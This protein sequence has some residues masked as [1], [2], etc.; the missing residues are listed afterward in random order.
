MISFVYLIMMNMLFFRYHANR[1]LSFYA[2]G[3]VAFLFN[4]FIVILLLL[5]FLLLHII[6]GCLISC[7]IISEI[8]WRKCVTWSCRWHLQY[9]F[10]TTKKSPRV[11][12]ARLESRWIMCCPSTL[13]HLKPSF[14][15]WH[16]S[17]PWCASNPHITS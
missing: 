8:G 4:S 12:G 14:C 11:S 17:N 15:P 3:A 2:P 16:V 5:L 13:L 9:F 10:L 1:M 6:Y 7:I